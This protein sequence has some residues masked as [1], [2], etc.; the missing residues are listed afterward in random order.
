[1][2]QKAKVSTLGF[3]GVRGLRVMGVSYGYGMEWLEFGGHAG[4]SVG[5][6]ISGIDI[7]CVVGL[8]TLEHGLDR[9]FD[10]LRPNLLSEG[11]GGP[12]GKNFVCFQ[13]CIQ[14]FERGG[15]MLRE[16]PFL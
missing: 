3:L 13:I 12:F 10:L 11:G 16:Q 8:A 14:I 2:E 15:W 1:M 9:K 6:H 4:R 7:F 5:L